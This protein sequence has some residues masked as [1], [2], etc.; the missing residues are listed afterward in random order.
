MMYKNV[1][2]TAISHISILSSSMLLYF[3]SHYNYTIPLVSS[4]PFDV[5]AAVVL[6]VIFIILLPL[7]DTGS[8]RIGPIR[9]LAG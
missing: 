6:W 4:L 3:V 9:I 7:V 8:A 2:A 5:N 1:A